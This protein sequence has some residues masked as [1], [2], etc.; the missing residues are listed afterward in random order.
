LTGLVPRSGE[1]VVVD[2]AA[3]SLSVVARFD[4]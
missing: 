3:A 1:I 4:V 2:M